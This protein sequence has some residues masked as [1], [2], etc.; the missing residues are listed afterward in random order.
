VQVYLHMLLQLFYA[1][2]YSVHSRVMKSTYSLVR[3][4]VM[5]LYK[6]LNIQI[7]TGEDDRDTD[8]GSEDEE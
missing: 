3:L 1:Y 6:Q 5:A 4:V 2:S 7:R 8:R